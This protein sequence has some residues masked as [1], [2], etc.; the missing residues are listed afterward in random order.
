MGF[1]LIELLVVIAIIGVLIALLLP[2]V[3]MAREAARRNTCTNNLKQIALALA[4][5]HDA[6]N[7]YPP[8]GLRAGRNQWS[9]N[10]EPNNQFRD[11]NAGNYFSMQ[12]HLLPYMD[13]SA[14][15]EQFNQ[16]RGAIHWLDWY[17]GYGWALPD[18][19]MTARMTIVR[20][21]MCPSDPNPGNY[22]RQAHGHSYAPNIGQLRNFRSWFANGI[23]YQPGWDGALAGP[24]TINSIVDGTSKTAAWSEW[25]KGPSIDNFN[26][27]KDDP[28]AWVWDHGYNV[29]PAQNG[30]LLTQG[31]GDVSAQTG[32]VWFNIMCNRSTTPSW[33]WKGEYWAVGH[34]GRGSGISFSVKPNGNSCYGAGSDPTDSGMAASSR[35]PGGVNLAMLDGSV[36]FISEAIDFRVWWAMGSRN[37]HESVSNR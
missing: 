25:V 35:H 16:D 23:S 4:N 24:V 29:D 5:Y 17:T 30:A 18:T 37:G 19:Q 8:D 6:Y 1:T 3:Q 21:Y 33:A 15:Y 20:T 36:S 22:D 12:V 34:A 27:A 7:V 32:D 31:F 10:P 2:A 14:L 11:H 28:K 26:R 13:Q 9:G